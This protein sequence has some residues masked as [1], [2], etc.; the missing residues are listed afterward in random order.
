[1]KRLLTGWILITLLLTGCGVSARPEGSGGDP[2]LAVESPAAGTATTAPAPTHTPTPPPATPSATP[3]S[4]PTLRPTATRTPTPVALEPGGLYLGQLLA[5]GAEAFIPAPQIEGLRAQPGET[6][7]TVDYVDASGKILLVADARQFPG[8]MAGQNPLRD[9]LRELYG[10]DSAYTTGSAFPRYRFTVE[11]IEA[12]FYGLDQTLSAAQ[13]VRLKEALEVFTRPTFAPMQAGLFGE[14]NAFVVVANL[15]DNRFGYNY[16]GTGFVFLDRQQLFGNKYLLASVLAHEG[17]HVLQG[18]ILPS[19]TCE[20]LLRYE[21][22][23]KRIPPDLQAWS[24]DRVLQEAGRGVLGAYHVT[25]WM[26]ANLGF[27]N[28]DSLLDVIQTGRVGGVPLVT[29]EEE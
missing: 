17:A 15:G 13:I 19:T 28:L 12:G 24:G 16:V 23:E 5:A 6:P 7:Y 11:G 21:V 8:G 1:M 10:E 18:R 26:L 9:T 3:S 27:N 25:Y 14:R 29:C 2:P 22:G 4:T 20:D